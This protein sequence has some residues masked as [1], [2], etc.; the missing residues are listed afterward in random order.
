MPANHLTPEEFAKI[1][2]K[3]KFKNTKVKVFDYKKIQK[4]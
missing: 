3:T 2:K 4:L 1:V